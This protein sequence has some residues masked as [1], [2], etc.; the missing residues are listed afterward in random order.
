MCVG[1]ETFDADIAKANR[2]LLV[3]ETH[4]EKIVQFCKEKGINV[5]AFY[6]LAMEGDTMKSMEQT[7]RQAIELNTITARFSVSTPYPGTGYFQQLKKDQ[8]LLTENYELYDQFT[9][10]YQQPNLSPS[11]VDS[12]MDKAYRKYYF[13]TSYLVMLFRWWVRSFLSRA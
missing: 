7:L 11:Q 9:M 1:I 4:Q 13:R 6:V 3:E 8:R 12:F 5:S 2:R 10:V